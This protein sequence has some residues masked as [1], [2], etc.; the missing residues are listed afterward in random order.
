MDPGWIVCVCG[1]D[2]ERGED[3]SP[4]GVGRA[5]L[6]CVCVCRLVG[7]VGILANTGKCQLPLESVSQ[8]EIV[9]TS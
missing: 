7:G 1:L 9:H 2:S 4:V 3:Y 8:S 6:V 5:R